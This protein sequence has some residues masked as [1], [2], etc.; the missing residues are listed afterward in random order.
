MTEGLRLVNLHV[1][2]LDGGLAH[3]NLSALSGVK[4]GGISKLV[5][6][7]RGTIGEGVQ[8]N[9]LHQLNTR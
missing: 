7:I 2:Y 6:E 8:E 4:D 1:S 3:S 9:H 5:S